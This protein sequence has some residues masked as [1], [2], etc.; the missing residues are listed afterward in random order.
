M[1]AV[2]F[3][4]SNSSFCFPENAKYKLTAV[5]II[6]FGLFFVKW[7]VMGLADSLDLDDLMALN[8][9]RM[10]YLNSL[11]KRRPSDEEEL[12]LRMSL[13]NA[14]SNAREDEQKEKIVELVRETFDDKLV[15]SIMEF[16]KKKK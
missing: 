12:R 1:R 2:K 3:F 6:R 11:K 9:N 8:W 4:P 5:F 7:F 14:F 15:K 16:S 10:G 13:L